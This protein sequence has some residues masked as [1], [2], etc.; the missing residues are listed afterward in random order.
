[1]FK[2]NIFKILTV[3]F[4]LLLSTVLYAKP[5]RLMRS[6]NSPSPTQVPKKVDQDV[7]ISLSIN[8]SPVGQIDMKNSQNHCDVLSEA[9]S[10]K[11]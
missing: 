9:L 4:L 6:F 8:G 10:Q 1:M 5:I 11:K 2:R 3:V 7:K